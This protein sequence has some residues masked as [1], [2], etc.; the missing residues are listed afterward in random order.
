MSDTAISNDRD[1][2]AAFPEGGMGSA[3]D[4]F[5]LLKPRV[6]SLVIFTA[7]VGIAVAPGG[8]HPV[9][10][11]TALL[12]I[13]VGAGASGA[14]NM[15]YDADIDARM[16]RTANR[17][18]PAGRVT[19]REAAVF[20]SI[21]SVFAVMTMG[22][23]VNWVAA[24]LLAFTIFFYLVVYTMWLKRRTSQNIVIGGA[25]GAFPPMIG[26]AAVTGS[27]S[28]ESI[29]LFLIIFMWTP[30]HFWALA[31]YRSGDYEKVGVPMLPVVSGEAETR[32]QIMLY[33]L[34]LVPVT[35]LPGFLGFAGALYMG[36]TA[37]L[38]A[39]FLWLAFGV[40]RTG[41]GAAQDKA[42]KR[43]FGYSILYLFLIFSLLLAEKMLGL[44][45]TAFAL[46]L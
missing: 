24:A 43:L 25:A 35:L 28:V 6:M 22:V 7:L 11:F 26:W 15:W 32:R 41:P 2:S 9:I 31:L 40:W 14:L 30:P 3:R 23:L 45:G 16:A 8:I 46:T 13:A 18:I 17:P 1:T 37:A 12:C 5:Q 39:G 10:G 4:F 38:G 36:A 27:V 34:A 29:A 33:S 42:A 20:G 44:G 21:L 19:A